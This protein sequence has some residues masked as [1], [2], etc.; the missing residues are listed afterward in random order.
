M[1]GKFNTKFMKVGHFA[2]IAA[3]AALTTAMIDAGGSKAAI[4]NIGGQD[5]DVTTFS[6]SYNSDT[7]RFNTPANGGVMPWWGNSGL[8]Q[9]F[10][11]AV[12]N[13][14]GLV[15]GTQGPFFAYELTSSGSV[16][17]YGYDSTSTPNVNISLV[18]SN[19]GGTIAPGT[20][21]AQA[22]LVAPSAAAAPGPLPVMGAAVA[23]GMSRRLRRRI[24]SQ[25]YK[26]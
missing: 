26:F 12:G 22:S 24:A 23:F 11:T 6:G 19:Y 4:F 7:S 8:A 16:R 25:P 1:T 13:S 15:L 2:S 10:A 9:Q 21:Y 20:Y 3:L 17:K 14:M 5:Y 18:N